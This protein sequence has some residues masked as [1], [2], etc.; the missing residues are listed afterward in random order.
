MQS[1]M[2]PKVSTP[3]GGPGVSKAQFLQMASDEVPD[4]PLSRD[5]HEMM[6]EHPGEEPTGYA[7]LVDILRKE[8]GL[9]TWRD[10]GAHKKAKK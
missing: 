2:K 10:M 9:T 6:M 1:S 4:F 8:M 5:L 3:L 7:N